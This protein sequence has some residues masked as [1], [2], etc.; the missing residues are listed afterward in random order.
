MNRFIQVAMALMLTVT[1][2][3]VTHAENSLYAFSVGILDHD[4]DYLWSDIRREHGVDLN[5][6]AIFSPSVDFSGGKIRPALGASL[7]SNGETSKI[8]L[9]AR[10]DSEY[11][12][13]WF[14][15]I[16]LGLA[17]HDG[18]LSR[19]DK[20]RKALGSRVLFH[21]PLEA[22]Y[23]IGEQAY[24]SIYFDHISNAGL[25]DE[26]QGMDTLGIRYRHL[27]H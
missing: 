9:D 23:R 3:G 4:T 6:E 18:K 27:F 7:N 14:W 24:L 11:S 12:K 25:K 1:L 21:V 16:G 26:N 8:Y 10:W 19:K 13:G 5:L 17:G 15:G 20:D 2:S 22:G